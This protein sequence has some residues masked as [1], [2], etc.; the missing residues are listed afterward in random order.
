MRDGF[1]SWGPLPLWR[2][3]ILRLVG[4]SEFSFG[5]SVLLVVL[6]DGVYCLVAEAFV[7]LIELL[8]CWW[9]ESNFLPSRSLRSQL[10]PADRRGARVR[11][12]L[13]GRSDVP[14][15]PLATRGIGRLFQA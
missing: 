8:R 6:L 13:A 15:L 12:L 14:L 1:T 2:V 11:L 5:V 10:I 3:L 9:V 7:A 4:V